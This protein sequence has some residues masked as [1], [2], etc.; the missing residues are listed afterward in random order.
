M[1]IVQMYGH[2][3]IIWSLDKCMKTRQIYRHDLCDD[4]KDREEIKLVYSKP[5][6]ETV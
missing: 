1:D 3:S 5:I 4:Y 2:L 6:S